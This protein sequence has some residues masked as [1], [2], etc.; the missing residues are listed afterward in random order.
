MVLGLASMTDNPPL[1]IVTGLEREA[2]RLGMPEGDVLNAAWT[3]ECVAQDIDA[4]SG[5]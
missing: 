4:Q 5:Q 3:V 2:R 1:A